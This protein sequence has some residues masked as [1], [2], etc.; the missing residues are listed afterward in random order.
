MN[1]VT[2]NLFSLLRSTW[3]AVSKMFVRLFRIKQVKALKKVLQELF[4][5]TKNGK[6]ETKRVLDT[7][8]IP[9]LMSVNC[10]KTS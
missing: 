6:T 10:K 5:K 8:R 2:E 9:K 3:P 1:D 7:L 4:T